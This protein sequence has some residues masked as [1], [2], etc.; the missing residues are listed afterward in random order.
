[1]LRGT[2]REGGGGVVYLGCGPPRISHP[3]L[4]ALQPLSHGTLPLRAEGESAHT[5]RT[6]G[7]MQLGASSRDMPRTALLAYL[8][9]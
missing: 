8:D 7:N 6:V 1:M 5:N 3:L 4:R 9:P 2:R